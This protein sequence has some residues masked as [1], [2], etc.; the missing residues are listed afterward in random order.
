MQ[1]LC[2]LNRNLLNAFMDWS[3]NKKLIASI[4]A[5]SKSFSNFNFFF[6]SFSETRVAINYAAV[7]IDFPRNLKQHFEMSY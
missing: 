3:K 6:F 4:Y 2:A 1:I 5:S 7:L